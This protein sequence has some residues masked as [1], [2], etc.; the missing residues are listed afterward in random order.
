MLK[1]KA[2]EWVKAL[3]SGTYKQGGGHLR[4]GEN[5]CCLGVLADINKCPIKN[6]YILNESMR[7]SCGLKSQCGRMKTS[8]MVEDRSWDSLSSANDDGS[9]FEQ[10]ADHIEKHYKEL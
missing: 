10:I 3:R 4:D 6:E 8:I 7:L 2:M 9:T 5:Y 1:S